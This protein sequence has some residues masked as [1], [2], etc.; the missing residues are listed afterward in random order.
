MMNKLQIPKWSRARFKN[1]AND[2]D[3]HLQNAFVILEEVANGT[4]NLHYGMDEDQVLELCVEVMKEIIQ[5]KNC[6][7]G[8]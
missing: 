2:T 4:K 5:A 8:E 3:S 1:N 7:K 6:I